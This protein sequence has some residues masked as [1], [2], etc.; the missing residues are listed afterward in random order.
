LIFTEATGKGGDINVTTGS[1]LLN[2][3]F[4]ESSTQDK[5]DAGNININTRDTVSLNDS[6]LSTNTIFGKGKGGDID[7]QSGNLKVDSGSISTATV[8]N[9]GGDITVNLDRDLTLRNGSNIST[10]A[11]SEQEGGDEGSIRLK[12]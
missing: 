11:G 4:L 12:V 1:M 3:S 6:N 9:D 10:S 8:R 2:N 7:I 5:G